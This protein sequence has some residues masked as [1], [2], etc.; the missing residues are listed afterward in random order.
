M[1]SEIIICFH[2]VLSCNLVCLLQLKQCN[3]PHDQDDPDNREIKIGLCLWHSSWSQGMLGIAL[4]GAGLLV[5]LRLSRGDG[6]SLC[7][8]LQAT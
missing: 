1:T 2:C 3:V 5:W 4:L 6:G 7:P 8:S